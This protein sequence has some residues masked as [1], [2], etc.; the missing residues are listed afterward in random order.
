MA[1]VTDAGNGLVQAI[2]G[3]CYPS[4]TGSASITGGGFAQAGPTLTLNP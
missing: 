3:I 1:D 4:G 2:A